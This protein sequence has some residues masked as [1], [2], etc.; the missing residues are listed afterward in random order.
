MD[1]EHL[2]YYYLIIEIITHYHDIMTST[3]KSQT[4]FDHIPVT[5]QLYN[6]RK[7]F[8]FVCDFLVYKI[9]LRTLE[10]GH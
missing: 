2:C 8:E 4:G 6:L 5:H 3:L 9:R 1:L 7:L 10:F